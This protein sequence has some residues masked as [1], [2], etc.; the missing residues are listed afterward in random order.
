MQ[1]HESEFSALDVRIAVVTF[2]RRRL[3][4]AYVESTGCAWPVLVD[5]DR[6]LYHAYGMLRGR[7]QDIM[8]LRT[9]WAYAQELRQGRLPNLPARSTDT[10][11]LGGDV[12]IDPD[13]R[14]G[15]V[16]VGSGPGD[17]PSIESL[18]AARRQT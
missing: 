15:F 10:F 16:H 12:L 6:A 1:Q 18:L 8:G 5:E 11:Q 4:Q 14:V 9:W 3:A 2:D 13:G 17:R 7:W